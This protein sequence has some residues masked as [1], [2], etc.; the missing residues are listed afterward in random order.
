MYTSFY[1]V[2]NR[3][4]ELKS[5]IRAELP[6]ARFKHNPLKVGG[7]FNISLDL[8]VN[9]GNKLSELREK[10]HNEDN[11]PKSPNKSI[12]NKILSVFNCI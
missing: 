5:F 4:N 1:I 2:E 8:S 11:P 7:E 12:W 9:D 6:T 3:L 10:W